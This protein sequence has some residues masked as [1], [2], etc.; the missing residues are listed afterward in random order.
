[1]I[2]DGWSYNTKASVKAASKLKSQGIIL[3]T[4]GIGDKILEAEID[5]IASNPR[6]KF[7]F[8][9]KTTSEAIKLAKGL[10]KNVC[11]E[12][13][14]CFKKQKTYKYTE[15]SYRMTPQ[16]CINICKMNTYKY[17]NIEVRYIGCFLDSWN[18]LLKNGQI[19]S[20]KMTPELCISICKDRSYRYCGVQY[21]KEC[22]CGDDHSRGK[23]RPE[24][25]CN[26]GCTGDQNRKCGGVWRI[27][28]FKTERSNGILNKKS[29]T[30][31][32]MTNDMCIAWCR[33]YQYRFAGTKE[34]NMCSCGNEF[35]EKHE[36][37][38][39]R[40]E[41]NKKCSGNKNHKC[42]GSSKVSI[43]NTDCEDY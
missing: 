12:Y 40:T 2:T 19:D 34:G 17:A 42:G 33:G 3:Y 35:Y 13:I 15:S 10:M 5:D 38:K 36:I 39:N 14:G 24:S 26:N 22:F 21:S 32:H 1:M 43:F 29:F 20:D 16:L 27:N 25:E 30:F 4:I 23:K 11:E 41:C 6:K 31:S 8:K 7:S 9:A 37:K 18:R 28:V